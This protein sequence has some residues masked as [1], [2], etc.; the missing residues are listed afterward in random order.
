VAISITTPYA[1][2]G[3]YLA[4]YDHAPI[5]SGANDEVLAAEGI[6]RVYSCCIATTSCEITQSGDSTLKKSLRLWGVDALFQCAVTRSIGAWLTWRLRYL[7]FRVIQLMLTTKHN[8]YERW[9]LQW[10]SP[11][12]R[13]PRM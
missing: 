10:A 6:A 1:M 4:R 11:L 12:Q 13:T 5:W 9:A 2:A 8:S 7:F 3:R